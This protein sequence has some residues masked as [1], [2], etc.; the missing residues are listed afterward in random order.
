MR[1]PGRFCT[2]FVDE[3]ELGDGSLHP[4]STSSLCVV[5]PTIWE[6]P[7]SETVVATFLLL[8]HVGCIITHRRSH[9]V[10]RDVSRAM[11]VVCSLVF[12]PV[13]MPRAALWCLHNTMLRSWGGLRRHVCV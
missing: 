6:F 1:V 12:V 7:V 2:K 3:E 13:V 9:K 4:P 11:V 10:G 5:K 8:R